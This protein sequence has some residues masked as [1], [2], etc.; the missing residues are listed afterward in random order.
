MT[1]P[2]TVVRRPL[3]EVSVRVRSKR[4]TS[5]LLKAIRVHGRAS[6]TAFNLHIVDKLKYDFSFQ[7]RELRNRL[8]CCKCIARVIGGFV[9]KLREA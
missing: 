9:M 4:H 8:G 1:L 6:T 3:R 2:S 5:R 7:L